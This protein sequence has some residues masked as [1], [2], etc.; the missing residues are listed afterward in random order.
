[1]AV[2]NAFAYK[3]ATSLQIALGI[4]ICMCTSPS[5]HFIDFPLQAEIGQFSAFQM[6]AFSQQAPGNFQQPDLP[7]ML[8][9]IQDRH[10]LFL[11]V[12]PLSID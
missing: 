12:T 7:Q 10:M 11:L 6:A 5:M 3:A 9:R 2:G 8:A 1:M 4:G